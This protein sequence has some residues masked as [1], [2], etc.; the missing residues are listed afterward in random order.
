MSEKSPYS[1]ISNR[2]SHFDTM[3]KL[4]KLAQSQIIKFY[5]YQY[6]NLLNHKR[7]TSYAV[8]QKYKI[9]PT[10]FGNFFNNYHFLNNVLI[11]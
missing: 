11:T 8:F 1:V 4:S 2:V 6:N 5:L 9:V 10:I 3:F 7:L